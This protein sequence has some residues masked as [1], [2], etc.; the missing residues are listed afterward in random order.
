[1]RT[2]DVTDARLATALGISRSAVQSRRNGGVKLREDQ[3]DEMAQALGVP[4][5]LFD[6]PAAAVLRWLAD[7]RPEQVF[8]ASGWFSRSALA[9]AV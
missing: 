1:M 2:L 7:N 8:A 4:V 5:D 3:C 6:T 9:V